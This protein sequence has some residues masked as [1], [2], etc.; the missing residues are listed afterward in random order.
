MKKIKLRHSYPLA[1]GGGIR[2]SAAGRD[3]GHLFLMFGGTGLC[4]TCGN[5]LLGKIIL[6][7]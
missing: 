4:W 7:Q 1:I 2:D 5:N 3:S 6:T